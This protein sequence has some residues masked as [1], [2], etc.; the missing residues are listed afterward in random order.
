MRRRGRPVLGG[1]SGFFLGIFVSFDLLFFG[2]IPLDSVLFIVLPIVG[3]VLGVVLP[4]VRRRTAVRADAR[5]PAGATGVITPGITTPPAPAESKT[6]GE[7]A[8]PGPGAPAA[9][10]APATTAASTPA[11][12]AEEGDAP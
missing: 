4:L 7:A 9:P 12:T 1:I 11:E 5:E 10:A 2:V 6:A 3:L 8:P